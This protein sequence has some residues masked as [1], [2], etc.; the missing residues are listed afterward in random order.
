[1]DAWTQMANE[2]EH[3]IIRRFSC[4]TPEGALNIISKNHLAHAPVAVRCS[5]VELT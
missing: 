5:P 2:G 3:H 4:G 1:M